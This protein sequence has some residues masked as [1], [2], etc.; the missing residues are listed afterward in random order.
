MKKILLSSV[1]AVMIFTGCGEE[2]TSE[3]KTEVAPAVTTENK[4]AEEKLVD[5]VKQSTSEVASKI[6]EESKKVVDASKDA[7]ESVKEK[8]TKTTEDVVEKTQEV[9]KEVVDTANKTKDKIEES[10]N[11]IVAAKTNT[12]D[13][14]NLLE[15]GKGIY[16]KCA[17]CHGASAEKPALGKS[18]VIKGWDKDKIVS[19]LNGYKDGTYGG[20]M[21]G[22]MKSQVSNMTQEDIEA[23]AEYIATF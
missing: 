23:V 21:K 18:Q 7:V 11:T 9:T 16:L 1:V 20:V 6:S 17:G 15:K 8:V 13:S 2:K 14:T 22:V 5:Q 3:P 10:I 19:S 12:N 4:T